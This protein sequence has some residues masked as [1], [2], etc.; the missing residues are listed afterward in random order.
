MGLMALCNK[1]LD[2]ATKYQP[3]VYDEKVSVCKRLVNAWGKNFPVTLITEEMCEKYLSA[4]MK[5]RSANASNK[6][7]KNLKAMWNK[8]TVY[9]I[10]SNPWNSTEKFAH[11]VAPP[12]TP[13]IE[14]VLRLLAVATRSEK[15]FLDCYIQTGA[16]RSEIFR[17]LWTDVDFNRRMI[18]LGTRKTKDGSMKYRNIEMSD[19]LYQ[20]LWWQW[21]NR[22][23]RRSPYVFIDDQPGP[24]YGKPYKARRR[25]MAGL[26]KRAGVKQFGFHALRRFVASVLDS[27]NVPLKQIQLILGHSRPTTTDRYLDNL[28]QGQ[29]VFMDRISEALIPETIPETKKGETVKTVNPLK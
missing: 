28:H 5:L 10:Q 25:F 9:G 21:E 6:D 12:Y 18:R 3:K 15:I 4:Q 16:R 13:P 7:R 26:C 20:S 14:D 24:H 2:F 29:K 8:S 11:D 1:Y 23:F 19:S 27:K 17:L 22:K